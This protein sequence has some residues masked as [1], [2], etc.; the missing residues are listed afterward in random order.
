MSLAMDERICG[1]SHRKPEVVVLTDKEKSFSIMTTVSTF[2][3][4]G[5]CLLW[6]TNSHILNRVGPICRFWKEV[7]LKVNVAAKMLVSAV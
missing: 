3:G 6:R 2:M 7:I 1:C 4:R 5:A